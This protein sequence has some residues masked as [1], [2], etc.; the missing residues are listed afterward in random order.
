MMT[1]STGGLGSVLVEELNKSG[2]FLF[3]DYRDHEKFERLKK[4]V[5]NP[6]LLQGFRA[7]MTNEEEVIQYFKEF[8]EKYQ[9]LDV[10]MHIM[11]GFWMGPE[12]AETPLEKW[13]F[14]INLNLNSA[15][16]CTREAF[17]IMK[18]QC[19]GKIITVGS[20]AAE[21]FPSHKGAYAVSK[22]GVLALT[23]VLANEGKEYNMQVNAILPSTIDT[24]EN[25][26]SMPEADHSA[27]VSP[28]DISKL[29][30]Y[31]LRPES[32]AL[33]QSFLKL[34]GKQ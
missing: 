7:D 14:M 21:E 13:N 6:D 26:K 17:K 2:A 9:R 12:I 20:R 5:K 10:F 32:S 22:A 8:K 31:L 25:R 24:P 29:I 15:F 4:G 34:Y 28:K 30:I 23:Q 18:V 16:L 27:W 19:S 33:S 11:G 3:V 1:G